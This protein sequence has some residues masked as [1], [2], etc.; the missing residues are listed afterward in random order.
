MGGTNGPRG[1]IPGKQDYSGGERSGEKK[2]G[3]VDEKTRQSE[4]LRTHNVNE[5]E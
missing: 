3:Q 4:G 1:V 5:E 2:K